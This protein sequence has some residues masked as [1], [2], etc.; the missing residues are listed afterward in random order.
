[1]TTDQTPPKFITIELPI[2]GM[3][4]AN[5]VA[6]VER[7]LNKK[8]PGVV[9]ASVNFA[10]ERATVRYTP[11]AVSRAEIVAAIERVGYG[12]VQ[13]ASPALLADAEQEARAAEIRDQTRKL[14]V[15][16]FFTGFIFLIAHNWLFLFLTVY[17][18]DSLDNWVYPRW[19]NFA[20][21]ALATPVQFY[22]GRDYYIGAFKSLRHGSAN[23]DVLV[24]LGSSVAYFYSAVVTAGLLSAPTY[25]ETAATIITLI[26]VGKLLEARAKGKT[27]AALKTLIGLQAKTARVERNGAELDLPIE[28]ERLGDWVVVRPG[29]NITVD[30]LGIGG[31]S[32]V[33]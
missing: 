12:V 4:C 13:A 1:M 28:Q 27:G 26:K 29:E 3:T 21:W 9:E 31:H 18:F 23:M 5:C 20:L 6:T 22:T 15:G 17:G 16:L 19:V 8:T 32:A 10:T 7:A 25:F 24:A 11:G 33:E 30:G 14:W 2:T